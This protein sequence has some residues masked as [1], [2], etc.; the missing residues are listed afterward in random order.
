VGGPAGWV[1][2]CAVRGVVR[3]IVGPTVGDAV[4][5]PVAGAVGGAAVGIAQSVVV[6]K[7]VG[8]ARWWILASSVGWAV[9]GGGGWA[10]A[11]ARDWA[12]LGSIGCYAEVIYKGG[13]VIGA[14]GGTVVGIAQWV[15]LRKQVYRAGWW[16]LAS[17]VGGALGG[18]LGWHL[19]G[20]VS[21]VFSGL[22]AGGPAMIAGWATSWGIIG[23]VGGAMTAFPLRWLLAH[24]TACG[25]TGSLVEDDYSLH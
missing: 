16:I 3:S 25:T 2:G 15:V 10:I 1:V 18:A 9:G 24:P 20:L 4:V 22:G 6:G 8:R 11:Y 19:G 21:E 17:T 13:A 12:V 14:M 23:A 5:G 7:Q